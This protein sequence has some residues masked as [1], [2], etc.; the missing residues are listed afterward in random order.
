MLN[1]KGEQQRAEWHT[2]VGRATWPA[3][4]GED[5]W[6][7]AMARLQDPSRNTGQEN[8]GRKHLLAGIAVCATCGRT[9]KTKTNNQ[10]R[11]I[12]CPT[13]GHATRK[14]E[15]V[16]RYVKFMILERLRRPDAREFLQPTVP[17]VDVAA[18]TDERDA[19]MAR[20]RDLAKDEVLGRRSRDEVLAAREVA[21]ERVDEINATIEA[22]GRKDIVARFIGSGDDPGE[23]WEDPDTTLSMR[24][25]L[26]TA[27]AVIRIGSGRNGRPNKYSHDVP[28]PNVFVDFGGKSAE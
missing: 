19:V 15:P 25:E 8:V 16:E 20:M 23:V 26:I 7:A 13:H 5:V 24:Q 21:S 12:S 14:A 28:P 11:S 27:L 3:V 6:R 22:V 10:Q 4:V 9:M 18:L 2:V 17:G 1:S